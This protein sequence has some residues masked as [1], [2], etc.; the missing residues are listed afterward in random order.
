MRF[1]V[2]AAVAVAVFSAAPAEAATFY[3]I[4]GHG[5][6]PGAFSVFGRETPDGSTQTTVRDGFVSFEFIVSDD[7]LATTGFVGGGGV[8]TETAVT[9]VINEGM[10]RGFLNVRFSG[11]PVDGSFFDNS[12]GTGTFL[13]DAANAGSR[14][15][16][17]ATVDFTVRRL[18]DYTGRGGLIA[19][20][21]G[22]IPEPATWAMMIGGFGL[23][24]GAMRRRK[25]A[26]TYA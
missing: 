7:N 18:A 25:A 15:T 8:I 10:I 20:S 14:A 22:A 4:N 6:G 1:V 3:Q 12:S 13:Y 24:G 23:V 11:N 17:D 26:V 21:A 9:A 16:I 5:T 19:L 2:S